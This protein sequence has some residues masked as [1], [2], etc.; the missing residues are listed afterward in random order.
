M[1]NLERKSGLAKKAFYLYEFLTSNIGLWALQKDNMNRKFRIFYATIQMIVAILA[2]VAGFLI[3]CGDTEEYLDCYLMVVFGILVLSKIYYVYTYRHHLRY[4]LNSAFRDWKCIEEKDEMKIMINSSR[5]CNNMAAMF[6]VSGMISLI[7]YVLKTMIFDDPRKIVVTD[8]LNITYKY[9]HSFILPGGCVYDGVNQ[10]LYYLILINQCVQMTIM[11][12]TN[13]GNDTMYAAI[14]G[15]ICVQFDI[16]IKRMKKFGQVE[17]DISIN[18]HEL[19][20]IVKRHQHLI[21]LTE[22]LEKVYNRIIFVQMLITVSVLSVGGV[23]LILS[24]NDNNMVNIIKSAG[25]MN[26]MLFESYLYTYPADNLANRAELMLRAIYSSYWYKMPQSI[27][28]NL[29]FVMMRIN[30]PPFLTCGKFFYMTRR[31]YMDVIKTAASYLSVLR[32]MIE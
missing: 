30:L 26:F 28:K 22:N 29:I 15:H 10:Y 31:S 7:S 1:Q 11:C 18:S 12:F 2:T 25:V 3:G 27:T 4:I 5:T 9:G 23:S 20:K 13:L 8:L 24:I 17:D 6:Y 14:T 21:S 19:G 32:I 16:L